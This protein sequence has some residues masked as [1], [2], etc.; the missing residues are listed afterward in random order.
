MIRALMEAGHVPE[1]ISAVSVG[2]L[3][4][5]VIAQDPTMRGVDHLERIWRSID[6]RTLFPGGNLHR[7]MSVIMRRDH[8]CEN[9]GVVQLID[10]NVHVEVFEDLRVPLYI[11]TAELVSGN[12]RIFHQGPLRK[13]LL[14]SAALPGV[15]P[16]VEV[17]GTLMIDGGV[18]S[19]IPT[20]PAVAARPER[21]FIL[22]VSRPVG[23]GKIPNT[24]IGMMIQAINITRNLC[25]TRDLE[26]ARVLTGAVVMPRPEDEPSIAFDDTSH[27]D[28]LMRKGYERA[29]RFL[30]TELAAA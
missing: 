26:A 11:S 2:A 10:D 19:N 8:V 17:D 1:L 4:G 9:S 20:S 3:N 30:E 21:L 23:G 24:P 25:A 14:A 7:V 15:F 22:D 29:R 28:E 6:A 13:V 27:T 12:H 18:V 16:P 5:A